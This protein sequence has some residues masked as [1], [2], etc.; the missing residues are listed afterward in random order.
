MKN[1]M[2]EKY[3]SEADALSKKPQNAQ[4]RS[5]MQFL[6]SAISVMKTEFNGAAI[7]ARDEEREAS[8]EKAFESYIRSGDSREYR[9]YSPMTSGS[10]GVIVPA[11]F[12]NAYSERLKD[13]VGVREAGANVIT[14]SRSGA[15]KYATVDDTGNTG[16]RLSETDTVTLANP[17]INDVSLSTFRY[18][19]KGVQVAVELVEDSAID[20]SALLINIFAKRIGRLTNSEF[21][22][23]G[24]GAMTGLVPS[25]TNIQ[26]AA[27]VSAISMTDLV[28]LQQIDEG[29]LPT[30]V[31]QFN[32]TTER[33]LRL[34]VGSDGR[35]LY[36][37]MAQ[38]ML[39]GYPFV[40]NNA[41]A[42][43][44]ANAFSVIFGSAKLGCTIR[45]LAPQLVVSA[46]RYAE[47]YQM[48]YSMIHRQ[49][50]VVNDVNALSVLQ[51]P[52]S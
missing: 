30:S 3:I 24:S 33:L 52:A 35:R 48:Y 22:V 19:S 9:T 8:A 39:L 46:Q 29:Y 17:T 10:D 38:G 14:T 1:Q 18:G 4:T 34:S 23:G 21:S 36:P 7:T 37:E 13:F 27:A 12:A 41:L 11:Q 28:N 50:F 16:E 43:P 15:L 45:E 44:A 32:Q 49:D 42:S 47:F 31:Y 25:I 2:L 26:A 5:R 40:R 20:L 6:T 51:H